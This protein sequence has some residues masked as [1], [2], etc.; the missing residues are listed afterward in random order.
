MT[1]PR[2]PPV[3]VISALAFAALV[4]VGAYGWLWWTG[5]Y[6]LALVIT[7][8][9]LGLA[10][11]YRLGRPERMELHMLHKQLDNDRAAAAVVEAGAGALTPEPVPA[12]QP[13]PYNR[14]TGEES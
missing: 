11:G 9:V 8:A 10:G 13:T 3:L 14:A 2:R 6:W 1:R 7:V 12:Q 5:R 4:A